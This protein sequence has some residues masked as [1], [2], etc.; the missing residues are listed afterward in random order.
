MFTTR[1]VACQSPHHPIHEKFF[2]NLRSCEDTAWPAGSAVRPSLS[3]IMPYLA[4][5]NNHHDAT[6]TRTGHEMRC[7]FP[8]GR[9]KPKQQGRFHVSLLSR[10]AFTQKLLARDCATATG[11]R[12][13]DGLA[14]TVLAVGSC[15]TTSCTWSSS[16][17][18]HDVRRVGLDRQ[19][20]SGSTGR[21]SL[22]GKWAPP[23][24]CPAQPGYPAADTTRPGQSAAFAFLLFR[25]PARVRTQHNQRRAKRHDETQSHRP[26]GRAGSKLLLVGKAGELLTSPHRCNFSF[27]PLCARVSIKAERE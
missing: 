22:V 26:A 6:P 25:P 24:T 5:A 17:R 2:V 9:R 21:R 7:A 14:G 4:K 3:D 12:G 16:S 27:C 20:A 1:L 10:T 18:S 15:G 23:P 11:S 8:H 13:R 19:L